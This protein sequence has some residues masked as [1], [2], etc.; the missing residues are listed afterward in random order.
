MKEVFLHDHSVYYPQV[1]RTLISEK[2][3]GSRDF[4]ARWESFVLQRHSDLQGSRIELTDR[5][6]NGFRRITPCRPELLKFLFAKNHLGDAEFGALI[7][8][9]KM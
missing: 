1:E 2:G 5:S 9:K 7:A 6:K 8:S 3:V 4:N